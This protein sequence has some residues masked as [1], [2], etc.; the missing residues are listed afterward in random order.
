MNKIQSS[1]MSKMKTERKCLICT[2]NFAV[3]SFLNRHVKTVHQ[4]IKDFQCLI[5][6][7]SFG[8]TRDLKSHVKTVHENSKPLT[9]L[10]G[11]LSFLQKENLN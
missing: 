6:N 8:C 10:I 7:Q 4:G 5:C 2:K 3:K 1:Y 9:C 11:N